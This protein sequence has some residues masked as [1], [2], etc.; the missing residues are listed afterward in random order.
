MIGTANWW[1]RYLWRA[2]P[3]TSS[4]CHFRPRNAAQAAESSRC[5]QRAHFASPDDDLAEQPYHRRFPIYNGPARARNLLP[6]VGVYGIV[7]NI[8]T[9]RRDHGEGC[10]CR[11]RKP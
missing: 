6:A 3:P 5:R 11:K 7:R 4:V 2:N 10:F 9:P 8:T 1:R